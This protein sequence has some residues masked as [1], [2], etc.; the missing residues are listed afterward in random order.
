MW[1]RRSCRKPAEAVLE[2]LPP[3]L[4]THKWDT[5]KIIRKLQVR[6]AVTQPCVVALL[7]LF[8]R[9]SPCSRATIPATDR[10]HAHTLVV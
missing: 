2:R 7:L 1:C 3:A 5:S 9:P 8:R 4:A 10:Q 6:V